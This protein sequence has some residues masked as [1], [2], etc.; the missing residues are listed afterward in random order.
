MDHFSIQQVSSFPWSKTHVKNLWELWFEI[1]DRVLCVT[2]SEEGS[3]SSKSG[4]KKLIFFVTLLLLYIPVLS[5]FRFFFS[6]SLYI[7]PIASECLSGYIYL[8]LG[9]RSGKF[10]GEHNGMMRVCFVYRIITGGSL[11]FGCDE[12]RWNRYHTVPCTC[13]HCV[14]S[15]NIGKYS[16]L[17]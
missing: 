5:L 14:A 9:W 6:F 12:R 16:V 2:S 15:S 11:F 4:K 17:V 10:I 1:F 8:E 13:H 7:L 3:M